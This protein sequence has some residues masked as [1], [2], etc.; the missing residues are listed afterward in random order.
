MTAAFNTDLKLKLLKEGHAFSF[1][2][3]VRLLGCMQAT[4]AQHASAGRDGLGNVRVRPNL[5]MG[6][7]A[8]DV[9]EIAEQDDGEGTQFSITANMLG[10]YGT[11]SPLPTFYTEELMEEEARDESVSRDFIDIINQRLYELLFRCWS[12]Y[13]QYL[14]VLEW[15]NAPVLERLFCLVGLGEKKLREDVPEPYRLLRYIGLFSQSPRSAM[16]LRALLKD[17]LGDVP[18]TIN[19]CIERN[20]EIP[21]SQRC[22]LGVSGCTLGKDAYL[23]QELVDRMGKFRIQVGPLDESVFQ[24]FFPGNEAYEQLTFLTQIYLT[25]PLA[26]DLELILDK[27][28]AQTICLGDQDHG[29]LGVN[30]WVFSGDYL[31]EMHTVFTPRLR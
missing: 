16:G 18:L 28:Q 9:E 14:Q 10:L 7:P 3:I 26:Y 30:S 6:F 22:C 5:S 19:P 8:S 1:F 31:D 27:G 24:T 12:K 15:G 2:Q 11:A 23:G 17:A 13:R 25:E 20:A 29:M 21:L 4:G